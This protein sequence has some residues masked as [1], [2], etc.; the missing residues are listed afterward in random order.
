MRDEA[1]VLGPGLSDPRSISVGGRV[2]EAPLLLLVVSATNIAR[3]TG[4]KVS[5]D[6][7]IGKLMQALPIQDPLFRVEG[8]RTVHLWDDPFSEDLLIVSVSIGDVGGDKPERS[9]L[10]AKDKKDRQVENSKKKERKKYFEG[11]LS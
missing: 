1:H 9:G 11:Y 6:P 10:R 8:S 5:D 3:E 7:L 4:A 2:V